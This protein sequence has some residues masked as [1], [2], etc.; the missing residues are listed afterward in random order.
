MLHKLCIVL[1][2]ASFA[3]AQTIHLTGTVVD[4][5]SNPIQDATILLKT[6]TQVLPIKYTSSDALGKFALD[7]VT[8]GPSGIVKMKTLRP[9]NGTL[10]WTSNASGTAT[11][12][13]LSLTGRVVASQNIPVGTGIQQVDHPQ[14]IMQ[15]APIG[16]YVLRVVQNGH[17]QASMTS[18][19]TGENAGQSFAT[20]SLPS[21][22]LALLG[23]SAWAIEVRKA[24]YTPVWIDLAAN[25]VKNLG[26]I[27]LNRDPIETRID[28]IMAKLTV[29]AKIAQMVQADLADISTTE[30][31][32]TDLGSILSGGDE[33]IPNFNTLQRAALASTYKVPL[34][35]GVD[36]VHGNSKMA[37][38]T[39]FPHNIG[40][41]ATRDSGLVR[42]MGEVTAQEVLG[43]GVNYTFAPCI[44]V[45]RDERWGR[46]YESF[47]ESPDNAVMMG[48][49]Y[50]RGLQ[51]NRF[52]APWRILGSAKHFLADGGTAFG[53]SNAGWTGHSGLLDQGNATISDSMVRAIHLPGYIAAVE[54]NVLSVM[55]SY[56]SIRGTKNH[57]NKLWLTDV[58]KTELGFE[59][60]VISDYNAIEQIS[61][62]YSTALATAI[63]AGVDM[64]MEASNGGNSY[65]TFTYTLQNLVNAG[66]VPQ[67]RI[68]DAVRRILRSKIR[69]GIFDNPMSNT[70]YAA[71]L[72]STEHRAIGRE[73]VRKSLVLL[74]D[75]NNVLPFSKTGQ[76]IAVIGAHANDAGLQCGGWSLS[77]QGGAGNI[78][79]ATT[80]LQGLQNAV[81]T[82][83]IVSTSQNSIPTDASAVLV[84]TGE[85]PY[86]EFQG[87]SASP[88]LSS[89]D[90]A[91]INTAA[92]S[93]KPVVLV[94]IS[95]RPLVIPQATLNKLSGL[96]AAW[97]PGTEGAGI[98]DILFGDFT[99]TG[100]LP[101]TWPK[102]VAQIP[103]HAGDP[104]YTDTNTPQYPYGFGLSW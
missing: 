36:A 94:L 5:S 2:V 70:T 19:F 8:G 27:T 101:I 84:V 23:A 58:L 20:G 1:I 80:I 44:A 98:A 33:N 51:G 48:D 54:A 3:Q 29:A 17:T 83:T 7:S 90:Q 71:T 50:I 39:I 47:G 46:T 59:G 102:S 89:A 57:A 45:A 76:K 10:S 78:S 31:T 82:S 53:T 52:D 60:F 74:K 16:I 66:T 32:S 64:A 61:G 88:Q 97:L 63:N 55:A 92:Q 56:S 79:G 75:S 49:A 67:S 77:W 22:P 103:I 34:I 93:G 62:N 38:T 104:G 15:N 21:R 9:Q 96:V 28:S 41:A 40:L 95:G 72:G 86:A 99:P 18:A 87:D 73:A 42:R 81:T 12:Q 13:A 91:M 69:A 65:A 37:G 25:T 100:K 24:G 30:I 4:A 85:Q 11:L 6:G 43:S 68:D 35:Y 26:T 14:G